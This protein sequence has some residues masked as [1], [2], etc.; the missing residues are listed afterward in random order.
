M[1]FGK[2]NYRCMEVLDDA[3]TSAYGT[4]SRPKSP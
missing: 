2:D 3:N 1:K 4:L